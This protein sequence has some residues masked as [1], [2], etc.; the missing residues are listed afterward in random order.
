MK[1]IFLKDVRPTARAGDIKDVKNGFARNFLLPRGLAAMATPDE[2]RRVEK[3]RRGAEVRRLQEASDWREIAEALAETPVEIT[4]R[5]G[6]RGRLYGSITNTMV[7][8]RLSE[9]TEREIDRRGIRFAAPIRQVGEYTVPIRLFEDVQGEI[10][11]IVRAED[12]SLELFEEL[13]RE[14]PEGAGEAENDAPEGGEQQ[15][16]DE[17]TAESGEEDRG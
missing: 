7:A 8:A 3:L 1:V 12:G 2:L 15:T 13:E 5:T 4:V 16:S 9:L 6:P 11:L 10:Q 17:A 14:A